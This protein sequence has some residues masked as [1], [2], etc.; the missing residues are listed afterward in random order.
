VIRNKIAADRIAGRFPQINAIALKITGNVQADGSSDGIVK[1]TIAV[2]ILSCVN[3]IAPITGND[4]SGDCIACGRDIWSACIRFEH[5]PVDRVG[6]Y[7][8]AAD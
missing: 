1:V 6:G 4:I 2:L 5:Q 7:R 3:A 8:V